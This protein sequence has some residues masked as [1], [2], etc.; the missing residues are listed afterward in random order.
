M[1]KDFLPTFEATTECNGAFIGSFE[2]FI[3]KY[4]DNFTRFI[5][6]LKKSQLNNL[7]IESM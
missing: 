6:H 5:D 1:E 4:S 7:S 3:N 2:Y